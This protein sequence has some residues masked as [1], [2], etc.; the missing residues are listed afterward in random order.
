MKKVQYLSLIFFIVNSFIYSQNCCYENLSINFTFEVKVNRMKDSC[1]LSV[2]IFEKESLKRIQTISMTSDYIFENDFTDCESVRSYVTSVNDTVQDTDNDF[3]NLIVADFD[4]NGNEDIVIKKNSGGNGGPM[5]AFYLQKN[6]RF[7]KDDF[8]TSKIEFFP[9][10]INKSR[11]TLT[12]LVHANAVQQCK[13]V[14]QYYPEK[15]IWK[16][17]KKELVEY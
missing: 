1:Q 12:T 14:Y 11:K 9:S 16:L 6:G 3:G 13:K 15:E 10:I 5:Y 7:I 2:L 8:L 4:F 17:V